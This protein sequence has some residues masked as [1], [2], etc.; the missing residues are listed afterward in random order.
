MQPD[1]KPDAQPAGTPLQQRLHEIIF[2]AETPAGK[3]FDLA[4][5]VAIVVS[6]VVVMLESVAE[7]REQWGR[8]LWAIEVGLTALFTVEFI[9]RLYCIQ[10]PGKYFTSFFGQVDF[11]SIVP[12]YLTLFGVGTQAL[13]VIRTLRLI[14]VFRVLELS[15]YARE[16]TALAKALKQTKAKIIVFL[17]FVLTMVLIIG[18]VMYLIEKDQP[19]TAFTSIPRSVYWAIVTMTTVGYGDISPQTPIGQT[20]AAAA[21][22]LGYSVIIVPMG[23]FSAEVVAARGQPKVLTRNCPGCSHEGHDID[24]VFCKRCGFRL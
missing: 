8:T 6:V 12:T 17:V 1:T 14:R 19:N 9:L 2:E 16:A 3:A 13:V 11:W 22:I 7:Y 23:I 10:R 5:L 20:V 15:N 18:S 24:A 21:M 4:L